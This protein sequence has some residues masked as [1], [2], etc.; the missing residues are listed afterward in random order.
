MPVMQHPDHFHPGNV[1]PDPHNQIHHRVATPRLG[2]C[3][4]HQNQQ[5]DTVGYGRVTVEL[6]RI[7]EDTVSIVLV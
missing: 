4:G 7:I 6:M 3:D 5:Q 2:Q 1:R